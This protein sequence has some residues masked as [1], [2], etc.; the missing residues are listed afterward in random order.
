M[1]KRGFGLTV[2]QF[3]EAVGDFTTNILQEGYSRG[4]VLEGLQEAESVSKKTED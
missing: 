2:A 1:A 4:E 3:L